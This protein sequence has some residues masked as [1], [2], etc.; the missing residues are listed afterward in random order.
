VQPASHYRATQEPEL[1]G[2]QVSPT[3]GSGQISMPPS[4]AMGT[5]SQVSCAERY[6]QT[7]ALPRIA[8]GRPRAVNRC[9]VQSFHCIYIV[10]SGGP[11]GGP[12][13]RVQQTDTLLLLALGQRNMEFPRSPQAPEEVQAQGMFPR[14]DLVHRDLLGRDGADLRAVEEDA[15]NTTLTYCRAPALAPAPA[16]A[17][18]DPGRGPDQKQGRKR[19]PNSIGGS[20]QLDG[21][22][23]R[24]IHAQ[25]GVF[26]PGHR[27]N[28]N[29]FTIMNH[30]SVL[31]RSA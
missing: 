22:S 29:P 4:S 28:I 11:D 9:R 31:H 17:P 6:P 8:S 21:R 13:E 10:G 27:G 3:T 16:P 19:G 30:N 1:C 12:P 2:Q 24:V 23:N 15:D 18:T 25:R 26:A 14:C 20:P 7:L 5:V